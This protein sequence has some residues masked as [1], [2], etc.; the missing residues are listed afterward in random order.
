VNYLRSLEIEPENAEVLNN[1][2]I[3]LMKINLDYSSLT[4]EEAL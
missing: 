3:A 4:F 1:L 2:G